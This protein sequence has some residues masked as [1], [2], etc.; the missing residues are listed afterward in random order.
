MKI[1]LHRVPVDE[2][3]HHVNPLNATL[4]GCDPISEPEILAAAENDQLESEPWD[5]AKG[6]LQGPEGRKFHIERIAHFVKIGLPCDQ[7]RVQLDLQPSAGK[8]IGILNGNHRIAAARIRG[9]A[10]IDA[11]LYFFD[12]ADITRLLPG[13][14]KL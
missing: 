7:F 10:T 3:L 9:D 11:L 2:L 6:R 4:W 8:E 1:E 5:Q 12:A 14:R 13:A